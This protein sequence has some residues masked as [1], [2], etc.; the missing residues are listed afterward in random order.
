MLYIKVNYI[1]K[2]GNLEVAKDQGKVTGSIGL[3]V[4]GNGLAIL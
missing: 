2:D 1:D 4:C 3:M